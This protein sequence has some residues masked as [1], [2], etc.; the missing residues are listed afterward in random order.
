MTCGNGSRRRLILRYTAASV[1]RP[2]ATDGGET[3]NGRPP[4]LPAAA[5]RPSPAVEA[6]F[7]ERTRDEWTEFASEHD[8]MQYTRRML[9]LDGIDLD[10]GV[11]RMKRS[12]HLEKTHGGCASLPT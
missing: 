6:V 7:A 8:P 1:G 2:I 9:G 3:V 11:T 4:P 5:R 12:H 10:S